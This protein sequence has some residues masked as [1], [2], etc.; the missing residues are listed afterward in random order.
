M[1]PAVTV[2]EKEEITVE[3][4]RLREIERRVG[5]VER[6]LTIKSS[7]IEDIERHLGLDGKRDAPAH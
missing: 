4:K 1:D 5:V 2:R 6:I 7:A 3:E